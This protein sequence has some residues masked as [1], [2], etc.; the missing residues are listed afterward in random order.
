MTARFE[1][2]ESLLQSLEDDRPVVA[3]ALRRAAEGLRGRG[4]LTVAA[5][6]E[7]A[8]EFRARFDA[9]QRRLPLPARATEPVRQTAGASAEVLPDVES[10]PELRRRLEKLWRRER[11][12]QIIA[13]LRHLHAATPAAVPAV[14]RIRSRADEWETQLEPSLQEAARECDLIRLRDDENPALALVHLVQHRDALSDPEWDA[15]V[16]LVRGT[17]GDGVATAVIRGRLIL[18]QEL[19]PATGVAGSRPCGAAAQRATGTEKAYSSCS[20]PRDGAVKDFDREYA[21]STTGFQV[22]R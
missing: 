4:R 17:F 7:G 15:C 22:Q 11:T 18:T 12:R 3:Y 6:L 13:V 9:L 20:R 8:R 19:Q 21:L 10:L 16:T 5:A 14:E 1:E 2:L